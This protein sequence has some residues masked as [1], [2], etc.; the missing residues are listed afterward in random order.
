MLNA[1]AIVISDIIQKG[2][3]QQYVGVVGTET[4]EE[5]AATRKLRP[6]KKVEDQIF[7]TFRDAI[8]T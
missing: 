6:F 7:C 5:I 2:A 3:D 8:E 1:D 4:K